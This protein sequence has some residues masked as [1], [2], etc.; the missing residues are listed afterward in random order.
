[1]MIRRSFLT[2]LIG[3]MLMHALPA[4][5]QTE[6]ANAQA[7]QKIAD[8]FTQVQTMMGDFI[9]FGPSGEQTGGKFFIQRPGK[10]LFLYE[11]PSNIRVVADG[12]NIVVNNKKLDT[13]DMYPLN[14]TPLNVVLG[15]KIDLSGKKVKSVTQATDLTTIVIQDKQIFGDSEI[16]MMFDPETF[17]LRQWTVKDA[18]GK[19][20]TV[21]I[22]DVKQGVT[23]GNRTF[24]IDYSRIRASKNNN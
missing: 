5:A 18:K 7:A 12:M 4:T 17:D 19:D 23:F 6:S 11:D 20:T 9:Q 13:W 3:A 16:T 22:Y 15:D 10:V 21:I 14:K 24:D 2:A 1:M 8:H